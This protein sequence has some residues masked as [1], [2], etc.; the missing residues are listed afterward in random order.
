[1]LEFLNEYG[2]SAGLAALI[3]AIFNLLLKAWIDSGIKKDM[4]VLR[5]EHEREIERIRMENSEALQ[6]QK[7]LLERQ[8]YKQTKAHDM[9][10]DAIQ[11]IMTC[12]ADLE[13]SLNPLVVLRRVTGDKEKDDAEWLGLLKE[14]AKAYNTF[15]E[16]VLHRGW[17]LPEETS[18]RLELLRRTASGSLSDLEFAKGGA[19][20]DQNLAMEQF[21]KAGEAV[22]REIPAV[23]SQLEADFRSI[24]AA[25]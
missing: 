4:Q 7:V 17:C 1:M 23:K 5:S 16:S 10:L 14:A 12:I 15:M 20:G 2:V 19:F 13:L 9:R 8:S 18:R 11:T 21:K 24:L 6:S 3:A 25:E 22:R